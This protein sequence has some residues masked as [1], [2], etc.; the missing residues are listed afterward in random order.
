[1]DKQIDLSYAGMVGAFNSPFEGFDF[2][3]ALVSEKLRRR[4]WPELF[5]FYCPYR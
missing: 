1:M 3:V 4:S 2:E 5:L